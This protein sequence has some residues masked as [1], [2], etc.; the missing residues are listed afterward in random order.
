MRRFLPFACALAF[1]CGQGSKPARKLVILHTNDEHSH[2]LGF[3]PESDDFALT[4]LAGHP[5]VGSGAIKGGA[6]RRS[7]VLKTERDAARA[8]GADTLTVSAGD[9]MMGTLMQV[10]ATTA[11]PDF[12][13]MKMLGY[14]VTTLGNHEFDYGPTALAAS[15]SAAK[16]SPEGIPQIVAT[17]IVFSG[18]AGDAALAALFDETG[19]D[20]GKPVHRKLVI[21]TPSGLK[22]GF[23]GIMGADAAAVAPL[24]APTRFSVAPG[25][26]DDN[27]SASLA[28]IFVDLQ[29]HVDS[30]RNQDKV[31][32][33]V[34]L[35]HSG[36]DAANPNS[37]DFAIAQ[38]VSGID[39]IVSGHTH[40]EVPGTLITNTRTGRQVLVQ[41]AGRF[42]DN[43]GR[44]SLSVDAAGTVTLDTGGSGLIK[45]DDTKPASDAAINTFVGGVIQALEQTPIAPGKPSFLGFTLAEILQ[46]APPALT[47]TGTLYN[48]PIAGLDYEVDNTGKFQETPLL[49]LAADAQLAA[50]NEIEPTELAVEAAGVL[51]VSKLEI[52]TK[53]P[54]AG[55]L[56]FGDVFRAVPL[57]ASPASGTPGYPLCRFGVWLAEVKAAFEVSA[58]FAYT[59]HDDLFLV[60]AG[61]RFEYDTARPAFNPAG[62]PLDRNNGRVT[63][64]WQLKP[65]ALAAGTYDG[66]ANY[67]LK[68]D[69]SLSTPAAPGLPA[70]WLDN[71]IKIVTVGASLYIA[72][73]ATFAGVS[74]KDPVTGAL[75]PDNDPTSTIVQR[76]DGTEVKEWEA[77]GRYIRLQANGGNLP[78]RYSRT[79]GSF[80]RRAI[81][82]GANSSS[83]AGGNCSH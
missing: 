21:V 79:A 68:F 67:D 37:E 58:G 77:V 36:A 19:G 72:T 31:D 1:A 29:P 61:F 12:R 75:I 41:Q 50:A 6:S 15:I 63:R 39:V 76:A 11:S 42:G 10:A 78:A 4:Y 33:V 22:V 20:T 9:N 3:G 30:L 55:K 70:G 32:L 48:Y 59:G 69:A 24:K 47:G 49:D 40:T 25:T 34:A 74:L 45:V 52:A 65:E 16:A 23:V 51:R 71:P 28:Q 66:D 57:G 53:T 64:I 43:V 44:I 26:T 38:N 56:G 14:D 17:N 35:S 54:F 81:C 60:P 83:A 73:F 7:A 62:D 5:E 18:T 27:R 8:A 2:L 13:V 80:P 46:T 82:V